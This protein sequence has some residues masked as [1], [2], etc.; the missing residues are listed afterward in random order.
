L[1]DTKKGNT[2]TESKNGLALQGRRAAR[3][4]FVCSGRRDKQQ[5]VVAT[6]ESS[7]LAC[8][9]INNSKIA[10]HLEQLPSGTEKHS[11]VFHTL[12]EENSWIG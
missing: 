12:S 1:T 4:H 6:A 7:C 8:T 2:F 11:I 3:E 5:L 10:E 9:L